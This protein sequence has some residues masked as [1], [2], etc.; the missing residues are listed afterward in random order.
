M[1]VVVR[2]VVGGMAVAGKEAAVAV[3][4]RAAGAMV[5]AMRVAV[6]TVVAARAA[7]A[8][9]EVVGTLAGLEAKDNAPAIV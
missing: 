3:V 4:T 7:V 6:A 8:E 2:E 5:V 9:A 1:R